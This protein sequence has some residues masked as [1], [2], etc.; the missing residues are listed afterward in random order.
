MLSS[1]AVE[2]GTPCRNSPM[3][4]PVRLT[5]TPSLPGLQPRQ[6]PVRT[7]IELIRTFTYKVQR[8]FV[9]VNVVLESLNLEGVLL[10]PCRAR[11][12]RHPGSRRSPAGSGSPPGSLA[13]VASA[14]ARV[15][16]LPD[17]HT[18]SSQYLHWV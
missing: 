2:Q 8:T 13:S 11:L 4:S 9:S 1:V 15:A 3:T 6:L 17:L 16:I 5:R 18:L 12:C 7:E 10:L 14:S